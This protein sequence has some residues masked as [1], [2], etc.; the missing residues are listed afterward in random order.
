LKVPVVALSP[1]EA[2]A[3]FGFLAR[4]AAMN[5]QGSSAK[6]QE[7]LGW[8]PTGPGLIAD[9]EEMRYFEAGTVVV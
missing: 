7:R 3:H 2:P 4:F 8:N 1:E 6:T 9:L 5:L